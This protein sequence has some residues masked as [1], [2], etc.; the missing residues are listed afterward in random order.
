MEP[1]L[2]V[3]YF[4]KE[5]SILDV[6]LGSN[7]PLSWPTCIKLFPNI[8]A[9]YNNEKLL[10]WKLKILNK[11]IKQKKIAEKMSIKKDWLYFFN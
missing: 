6:E 3:N 9:R 2:A 11:Y 5:A 4:R 10:I 1:L 7:T 8:W